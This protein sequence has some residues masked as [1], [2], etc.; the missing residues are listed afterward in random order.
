VVL[1]YPSYLR[2]IEGALSGLADEGHELQVAFLGGLGKRGAEEYLRRLTRR[3]PNVR[4]GPVPKMPREDA[5]MQIA[6]V[7][8]ALAD[9]ARY[10]HPRY[11][12]ATGLRTRVIRKHRSNRDLGTVLSALIVAYISTFGR[13]RHAG[14]SDMVSRVALAIADRVPAPEKTRDW[15]LRENPDLVVFSPLVAVASRESHVLRAAREAG[16]KTALIV[17]SWDN[18]TNKGL[19]KHPTDR[20]IV[21]NRIQRQEAVELHRIPEAQVTLT[22]APRFDAWFDAE[23]STTR[24]DFCRRVGL[25]DRR[26]FVLF[27]G[28]SPFVAPDEVPF[29]ERLLAAVRSGSEPLATAGVLVRP[30]PQNAEQWKGTDLSSFGNAVVWPRE[31]EM[32]I[33][34]DAMAAFYD[35]LAHCAVVVGIN[36]TAQIEAAIVG[37]SVHT[38][39]GE[40]FEQESTLHFQ[41]LSADTG[42][43]VHTARDMSSLLDALNTSISADS[44]EEQERTRAFVASFVRPCGIDRS[45]TQLLVWTLEEVARGPRVASP[46][47]RRIAS[48]F[49]RVKGAW[50]L[51]GLRD[52]VAASI[53]RLGTER[54]LNASPLSGVPR[55]D[56]LSVRMVKRRIR[57]ARRHAHRAIAVRAPWAVPVPA[58]PKG[59]PEEKAAGRVAGARS[60]SAAE[61]A[62]SAERERRAAEAARHAAKAQRAREKASTR[63]TRRRKAQTTQA[64]RIAGSPKPTR[65]EAGRI[66]PRSAAKANVVVAGPWTGGTVGE[67]LFWLPQL[68]ALRADVPQW[69]RLVVLTHEHDA[70]WFT[71]VASDVVIVEDADHAEARAAA[72]RGD[73]VVR[74]DDAEARRRYDAYLAGTVALRAVAPRQP[75]WLPGPEVVGPQT[76][77]LV[78]FDGVPWTPARA[79]ETTERVLARSATLVDTVEDAALAVWLGRDTVMLMDAVDGVGLRRLHLLD[80]V[81]TARSVEFTPI[82]RADLELLGE[83]LAHGV[84]TSGV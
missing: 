77:G 60:A 13:I 79:T 78:R 37:K 71:D 84:A 18:L 16:L 34:T 49:G 52:G 80:R 81:A 39:V 69:A 53:R 10:Q 65:A 38:L 43:F 45:S 50:S 8:Y 33:G 54:S 67:L 32:P 51:D 14:F 44:E 4:V 56:A 73:G 66:F 15:L 59:S 63:R 24:Q 1:L 25:D 7:L 40:E 21:W 47:P 70:R 76:D 57:R 19:L 74:I 23:P 64:R 58:P 20:V 9:V 48:A 6:S 42:G 12:A 36:T 55:V 22:G 72:L 11:A 5:W 29:V 3:H 27:L 30:H 31:G 17:A 68:H 28:S 2:N 83:L 46:A 35:S 62:R 75:I 26:P 61:A 82:A 41:Y